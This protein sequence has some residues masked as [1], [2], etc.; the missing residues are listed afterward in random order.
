MDSFCQSRAS[1]DGGALPSARRAVTNIGT[2][3][4]IA[5]LSSGLAAGTPAET[6]DS[7]NAVPARTWTIGVQGGF[8]NTFQMVLGGTFGEGADWQNRLTA[9]VNNLW[10]TGD[11]LSVFGWSTTDLPTATPNW[12]AGL[13]YKNRILKTER[14]N[15][16]L[17]GGVQRWLLPSVKT[18]A[19]DWLLSGNLS[20]LT[21]FKGLPITVSEDSWSLLR[22]TLPKGSAMST[23][24]ST[25]HTLFRSHQVQ[26]A[27]RHGPHHTY[28]WGFYGAQGNRVV[29]YAGTVVV[30]WHG[31][32]IEGGCRQQFGL[33][34]GIHNNRYWSMLVTRQFSGPFGHAH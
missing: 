18:G 30:V 12:Q 29:R 17:S 32:T 25:Q 3:L 9:S 6:A 10:R 13:I 24:I 23:Q 11:S 4:C 26:I 2:T 21:N 8:T 7:G 15:L 20:Y 34:D 14:H 22:S 1:L 31:T 28:A 27:L 5:V 33:Q 19:Q 16:F